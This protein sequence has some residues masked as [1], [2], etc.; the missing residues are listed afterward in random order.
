MAFNV[1]VGFIVLIFVGVVFLSLQVWWISMT[2]RNGRK[3]SSV[4]PSSSID[5][6]KYR[7]EKTF[8]RTD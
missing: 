8:S 7:L 1:N 3:E 4:K 6:I 5:E 2:I